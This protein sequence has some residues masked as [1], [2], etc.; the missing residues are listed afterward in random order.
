MIEDHQGGQIWD[1]QTSSPLTMHVQHTFGLAGGAFAPDGQRLLAVT[2]DGLMF[3]LRLDVPD[4]PDDDWQFL[5]RTV[6]SLHV[7][8]DG[9]ELPWRELADTNTVADAEAVTARWQQLCPRW[10]QLLAPA[11]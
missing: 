7:D 9:S 10:Q 1:V 8:A 4:W 6:T 3:N 5:V 2:Q 11:P